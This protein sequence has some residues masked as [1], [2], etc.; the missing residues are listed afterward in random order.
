M[1]D[2]TVAGPQ[3]IIGLGI[4]I[5]VMIALVLKTR[6]HAL[7]ALVI[8][9]SIAGLIGGMPPNAV[10]GAI[11]TGF[12]TTLSTI[13]LV[14]GFGV[15]M[16]RI[17]EVS[18]AGQRMAYSIL[19]LLGKEREDWAM[20]LTGYIVSIPIFCDSA[21]VI[22]NPLVRALARNSGRSILTLGIALA[23]GLAVTH[24]AVP[25]TPGPLGVAGIFGV[26]IGLMIAWGL[27]FTAPALIVMVLYARF[28]GP[29]IEA[30]IERDVP[31]SLKRD[32]DEDPMRGQLAESELP[33]LRMSVMPI[34]LPILLIFFN[35][36]VTAM[37]G[38]SDSPGLFV[39]VVQF[40]GH[41]VIAVGIG[42]LVA[43]YGLVPKMP[44]DQVLAHLEK[45]VESAGIILLV[46]GAG[47]ALGAV[48]R[49]SGAGDYIGESIAGLALPAVLIPFLIATLVRFVQGSG[50]VSMITGA[51][52]SAPILATMP[53]VNMVL[54][55]QAACLGG[56][57]FSYFND[58][59]FW[60]V[61][62]LL[63]VKTAKHQLLV[64]SVPTTLGWATGLVAL[65][66]ANAFMG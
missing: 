46:T 18:G 53:D 8:A 29:R 30:M 50:T 13:G 11:T 66:I 9:A 17:L 24:S 54:A 33:S 63:G 43:V 26:D 3:V 61:N 45:G 21:Y 6:V 39:Q 34:A 15:M 22:L 41:P 55:A 51:S 5:F 65:L 2:A 48:L 37:V 40:V 4:A 60:V 28:M 47:G 31:G 56:L 19:K 32:D 58:S 25:P 27:V 23:S 62:R 38:D 20:A 49:A 1:T 42:V 59:Y 52:I 64:L 35:T 14:I 7:L 44:K 57:F 16:G 12:G 36:L 10:I